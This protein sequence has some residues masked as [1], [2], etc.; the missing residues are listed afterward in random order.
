MPR[1]DTCGAKVGHPRETVY[2]RGWDDARDE[3]DFLVLC[4]SCQPGYPAENQYTPRNL[5]RGGRRA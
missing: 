5:P 2:V 1:C 3:T 4:I